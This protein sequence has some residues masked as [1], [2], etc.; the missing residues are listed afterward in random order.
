MPD[1][2]T[3]DTDTERCSHML[4]DHPRSDHAEHGR[5]HCYRCNCPAFKPFRIWKET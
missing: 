5:G 1:T 2:P 4:C 3:L